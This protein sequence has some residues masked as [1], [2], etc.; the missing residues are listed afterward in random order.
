MPEPATD[1]WVVLTVVVALA[2]FGLVSLALV[3]VLA[4]SEIGVPDVLVAT[5]SGSLSA[6]GTLLVTTRSTPPAGE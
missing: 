6:L 3:G 1:R 4:V 5:T 2:T